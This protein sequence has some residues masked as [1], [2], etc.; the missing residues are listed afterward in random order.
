MAHDDTD[1]I[2]RRRAQPAPEPIAV[3]RAQTSTPARQSPLREF[4]GLLNRAQL[5]LLALVVIVFAAAIFMMIFGGEEVVNNLLPELFGFALEGAFFM[6][7]FTVF[8]KR[9][10]AGQLRREKAGLKARLRGM[11]AVILGWA[12]PTNS[13][14]QFIDALDDPHSLKQMLKDV[15]REGLDAIQLEFIQTHARSRV[16]ILLSVMPVAANIDARHLLAWE[17]IVIN[18]QE[19]CASGNESESYA[20]LVEFMKRVMRFDQLEFET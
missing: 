19:L 6:I 1:T 3:P 7:L 4:L 17:A 18:L 2:F 10:S 20:H 5:M 13:Q 15:E 16:P 14:V 11:L 9:Q 8:E 12:L